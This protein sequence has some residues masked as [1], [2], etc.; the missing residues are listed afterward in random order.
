MSLR[1]TVFS[2]F[3][4]RDKKRRGLKKEI[5]FAVGSGGKEEMIRR[6]RSMRHDFPSSPPV[7]CFHQLFFHCLLPP[8][9]RIEC[10]SWSNSVLLYHSPPPSLQAMDSL[11]QFEHRDH[12]SLFTP[13][14]ILETLLSTLR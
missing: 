14:L 13:P 6:K 7:S 9:E 8:G 12:E 1:P 4:T 2:G 3:F 11:C 10:H 5:L